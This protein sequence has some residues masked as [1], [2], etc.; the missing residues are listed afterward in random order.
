MA[1]VLSALARDVQTAVV[2]RPVGC[3][4]LCV[5]VPKVPGN[6]RIHRRQR[7]DGRDTRLDEG[8]LSLGLH[9]L[10]VGQIQ[11]QIARPRHDGLKVAGWTGVSYKYC[12]VRSAAAPLP[13]A[14]RPCSRVWGLTESLRVIADAIP[15]WPAF[16]FSRKATLVRPARRMK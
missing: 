8:L 15:S 16:R 14:M 2:P 1:N 4:R 12:A 11:I 10:P 9:F 3:S 13:S 7:R 6:L 5:A